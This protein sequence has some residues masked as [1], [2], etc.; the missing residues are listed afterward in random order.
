MKKK[1]FILKEEYK[2][3]FSKLNMTLQE[4]DEI[5][6][7]RDSLKFQL[8]LALNKNKILKNKNNCGDVLKKNEVLSSKREIVLKENESLKNKIALISKKLDLVSNENKSL[9][10]FVIFLVLHLLVINMLLAPHL[11]HLLKVIY[12]L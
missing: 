5:S 7:E 8:N 3:L 11:L 6:N 4:R 9:I 2:D 12:V 1:S 10:M